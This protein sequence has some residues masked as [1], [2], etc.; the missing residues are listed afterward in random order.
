[1]CDVFSC[2]RNLDSCL[3][4][5][6]C[7]DFRQRPSVEICSSLCQLTSF[8]FRSAFHISKTV[9][10][11]FSCVV[12]LVKTYSFLCCFFF[13][14]PNPFRQ[15]GILDLRADILLS[16]P[17]QPVQHTKVVGVDVG[18]HFSTEASDR[19]NVGPHFG[20]PD[21]LPFFRL[22]IECRPLE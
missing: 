21:R 7:S 11:S 17:R 18:V 12:L 15:V 3:L 2:Q 1:M 22:R 5:F 10:L 20:S 19:R 13:D 6:R 14:L 16:S 9:S 4:H 8:S